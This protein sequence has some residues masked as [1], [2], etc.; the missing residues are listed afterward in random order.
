[1]TR[2]A[3]LT[4]LAIALGILIWP[5]P[6]AP[7]PAKDSCAACHLEIGDERLTAP[8]K[9]FAGDIHKAK[10]FGCVAC[11][12]GDAREEGLEAMNPAKGYIGT[13]RREQ[14]PQL[15][16][17]CH[18]DAQFMKRY[19]PALRVDQLAEYGTSVHG[20]RLRELNDP[21]VAVCVSCHP[22]HA[23]RPPADPKS[24]VHPLRVAET[25]GRCHGDAKYMAAYKIPTDQLEKYKTSV[26]ARAMTVK[27]DLS[28]PTCNDCHG[29]HGASPPGIA[30]VGNVCGQ[31]HSV[32]A[33][34]FKK[35][36]HARVFAEMGSPGCATCHENHAIKEASDAML[37]L[38]DKAVCATCHSAED[39][40]GKSAAEM[41]A[42]IDSLAAAS[43][44]AHALLDQA[45][46]AGME[47][48]Q[49]QLDLSGAREGLIK[50]RTAV[51]AFTVDAVKLEVQPG[52]AIADKARARGVRALEELRF[53][54][55]WLGVSL[56]IIV[57]LIAGLIVKIRQVDRPGSAPSQ[58]GDA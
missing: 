28:A 37:G 33:D 13:P 30:W 23:I 55:A 51:H 29:N 43:D 5:A 35:S 22:A 45:E 39:K 16:G 2:R 18:S 38:G 47:V 42:L 7:Q 32:M 10:G 12:G 20:R 52:L 21:K 56:V 15:C 58:R 19:N 3:G 8:A 1:M 50:A 34:L 26:H 44:R 46:R 40:A 49:G 25:C 27:G 54:K 11:H 4:A 53:R 6:G 14:I 17:R 9:A 31:C 36:V 24:S 41:R 57:A 48:S